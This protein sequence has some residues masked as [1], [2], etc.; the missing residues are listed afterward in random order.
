M[1]KAKNY[2][3]H[4]LSLDS[5]ILKAHREILRLLDAEEN[6][7]IENALDNALNAAFT[8]YHLLDWIIKEHSPKTK[9]HDFCKKTDSWQLLRISNMLLSLPL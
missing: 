4:L 9:T 6:R 7:N 1:K 2:K 5:M 3:K 8:I